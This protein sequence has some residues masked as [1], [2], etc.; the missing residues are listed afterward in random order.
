MPSPSTPIS[1]DRR[2][3]RLPV[4]V[5]IELTR[6][7]M[8]AGD[9]ASLRVHDVIPLAHAAEQ[10]VTLSVRGRAFASGELQMAQDNLVVRVL[11]LCVEDPNPQ[12]LGEE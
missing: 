7:R 2:F 11:S 8:S 12:P 5:S 4:E 10:P 1:S 3:S 6:V 9:I